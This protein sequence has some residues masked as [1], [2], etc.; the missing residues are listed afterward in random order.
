MKRENVE[1]SSIKSIGYDINQMILEVEFK[2]GSVYESA[3]YRINEC[4]F[5]W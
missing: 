5:S 1:S 2:N 4:R 3:L